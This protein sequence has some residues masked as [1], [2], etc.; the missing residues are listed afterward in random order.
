M[1]TWTIGSWKLIVV[2]IERDGDSLTG[3]TRPVDRMGNM[4]LEHHH[5]SGNRIQ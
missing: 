2:D 4:A 1:R 3:R 5:A